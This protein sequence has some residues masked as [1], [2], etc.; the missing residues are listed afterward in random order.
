MI[1]SLAALTPL[2]KFP[3]P[4]TIATSKLSFITDLIS[5][6]RNFNILV[7]IPKP[8]SPASASPENLIKILA[9]EIKS[10]IKEGFEVASY[11]RRKFHKRG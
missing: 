10:V 5:S 11:R 8:S 3:P 2:I 9:D 7:L 1:P 6:A 4:I